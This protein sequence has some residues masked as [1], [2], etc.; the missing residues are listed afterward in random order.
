MSV[1]HLFFADD[2]L[3]FCKPNVN[4][5]L[6]LK[7]IL[8]CF[9]MVSGIRIN[10]KKTE[11]VRIGDK[12]DETSLAIVLDCKV[13]NLPIKYL[14]LPLRAKYKDVRTWEP[15]IEMFNRRLAGWKRNFLSKAGRLTLIKSILVNL[16]IYYLSISIILA[17]IAKKLKNI[18]CKFL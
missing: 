1:S 14:G 4:V 13:S 18:Q 17:N 15:I 6:H 3:I 16:P 12:R 9:Q 5:I 2:A 8:L 11:M 7:C 10:L